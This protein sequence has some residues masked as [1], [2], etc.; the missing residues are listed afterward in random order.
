LFKI[1]LQ[2]VLFLTY[3]LVTLT[4]QTKTKH[5]NTMKTSIYQKQLVSKYEKKPIKELVFL[6]DLAMHKIVAAYSQPIEAEELTKIQTQFYILSDII[7]QK[8]KSFEFE[9]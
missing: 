6:Y 3:F 1:F 4:Y 2:I 5:Q 9:D 7:E 8:R